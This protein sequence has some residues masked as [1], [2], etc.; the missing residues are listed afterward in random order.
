MIKK[1]TVVTIKYQVTDEAGNMLEK[2][3]AP[4]AY[5]HGGYGNIPPGLEQALENHGAGDNMQILLEPAEGFGERDENLVVAEPRDKL[6]E[7]GIE[8]GARLEAKRGDTGETVIFT[9]TDIDDKQVTLDAN[10]P[11]AGVPMHFDI[12]VLDV[13]PASEEEIHHGHVQESDEQP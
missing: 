4:V 7:D 3:E 6:P 2:N 11:M 8:L 10:H 13:R 5:L 1:D 9:V 12:E